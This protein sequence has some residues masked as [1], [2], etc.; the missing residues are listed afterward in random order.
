M[1]Q[2][3]TPVNNNQEFEVGQKVKFKQTSIKGFIGLNLKISLLGTL[4]VVEYDVNNHDDNGDTIIVSD[5]N[6]ILSEHIAVWHFD[7]VLNS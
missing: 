5:A 6:G 4:T 3:N 1:T 7:K 2:E